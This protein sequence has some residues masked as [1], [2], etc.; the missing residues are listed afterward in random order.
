MDRQTDRRLLDE[1]VDR[2]LQALVR[3]L[4]V[5]FALLRVAIVAIL[6][7]AVFGGMFYV[8]DHEKA[9][10]FRFGE[11]TLKDGREVL[12]SG[13]WYWAYPYPI[14]QVMRIPAQR[15]VRILSGQ[16]WPRRN[17][18]ALE[19][20]TEALE[21]ELVPGQSGYLLTGDANIMHM[22][23]ALAYRVTDAKR[24]YLD[25]YRDPE[26]DPAAEEPVRPRGVV[27]I[28]DS[29]LAQEVLAETATWSVEDIY[30]LTKKRTAADG[31]GPLAS[32]DRAV[33][34]RVGERI[35]QLGL[36]IEIDQLSL[37]EI[38]PPIATAD[39]FREVE[40]A[41]QEAQTA[42]H[43]AEVYRER[44]IAEAKSAESRLTA[45]ARQYAQRTEASLEAQKEY[46]EDV[47]PQYEETPEALL[48]Q[49]M[50]TIRKL[51]ERI[52]SKYIIHVKPDGE[53]EVRLLL[54][55]EPEKPTSHEQEE[56][57]DGAQ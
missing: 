14:D 5:L 24:Y 21:Q 41:A 16:F 20:G 40:E 47:L 33:Q 3:A 37:V 9:M 25:F 1:G 11:L 49:Y 12:E 23:W 18:D 36:G 6:I 26:P 56:Q 28:I 22:L 4:H 8:K 39:A 38:L 43:E 42:R 44:V 17:V 51:L 45:E 32:L 30:G 31:E 35:R 48:A 27:A 57:G 54:S 46:F 15:S 50:D 53:Q 10:L 52:D 55:P 29:I 34:R 7:L 13:D 2:G 19:G